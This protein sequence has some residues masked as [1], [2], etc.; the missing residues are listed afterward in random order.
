MANSSDQIHERLERLKAS[1]QQKRP[2]TNTLAERLAVAKGR[3]SKIQNVLPRPKQ[4]TAAE[5][6]DQNQQYTEQITAARNIANPAN[7][8]SPV[9]PNQTVQQRTEQIIQGV[10]AQQAQAEL[11]PRLQL[12]KQREQDERYAAIRANGEAKSYEE[13]KRNFD[14]VRAVDKIVNPMGG[15]ASYNLLSVQQGREE[16]ALTKAREEYIAWLPENDPLVQAGPQAKSAYD[17]QTVA[18]GRVNP[19]NIL[20]WDDH[21]WKLSGYGSSAGNANAMAA[22]K[23][24]GELTEDE[25]R[26]IN[27]L[28]GAYDAETARQ[29]AETFIQKKKNE[30]I[31]AGE[32]PGGNF[33]NAS[34]GG[35]GSGIGYA[36]SM[37]SQTVKNRLL[38]T[39]RAVPEYTAGARAMSEQEA[40]TAAFVNKAE[41]PLGQFARQTGASIGNNLV[42]MLLFG[43][44]APVVMAV[45]AAAGEGYEA[46]QNGATGS[47]QIG[48]AVQAGVTEYL[49][50]KI[51]WGKLENILKSTGSK[52]AKALLAQVGTQ[53][54][55]E[56]GEETVNEALGM[57]YDWI[58]MGEAG[59]LKQVFRK[60]QSENGTGEAAIQVALEILKRLGG[61][62]AGGT[63][64]GGILGGSATMIN[65][66]MDGTRNEPVTAPTE[67]TAPQ[68]KPAEIAGEAANLPQTATAEPMGE[69][70]QVQPEGAQGANTEVEGQKEVTETDAQATENPVLQSAAKRP[71]ESRAQDAAREIHAGREG[72]ERIAQTFVQVE[73]SNLTPEMKKTVF[74]S[75]A[76]ELVAQTPY[77]DRSAWESFKP[78]RD[79]MRKTK[80]HIDKQTLGKIKALG[81]S[82]SEFNKKYG[83]NLTTM[84]TLDSL[85]GDYAEWRM[86]TNGVAKE[87]AANAF[88]A[89]M[90]TLEAMRETRAGII[91][92]ESRN[93]EIERV[94]N[95]LQ[96]Y[97]DEEPETQELQEWYDKRKPQQEKAEPAAIQDAARKST[98]WNNLK[99]NRI[100]DAMLN[101]PEEAVAS[102]GDA[103]NI[104]A[105][106]KEI[107]KAEKR[108]RGLEET[109]QDA[110]IDMA[111]SVAAGRMKLDA[112]NPQSVNIEMVE[113][114]ADEY[115]LII[116]LQESGL[117]GQK[118]KLHNREFARAEKLLNDADDA[119][120]EKDG[121]KGR[122]RR[123]VEAG[124]LMA[125]TSERVMRYIFGDG[126]VAQKAIEE[127]IAPAEENEAAKVMAI[128]RLFDEARKL[129]LNEYES[130]M[131]QLVGE[132]RVPEWSEAGGNPMWKNGQQ[133]LESLPEY[134]RQ[135]KEIRKL[136]SHMGEIDHKKVM[137]AVQ[138][139]RKTY[140]DFF[141]LVNDFRL[142]HG[143]RE[144]G[145]QEDYFPH[146]SN[147]MDGDMLNKTL[148]AF[149]IE[150]MSTLPA[151]VAGMT[152]GFRPNARWVGNFQK[153]TGPQTVFDAQMGF[154][155]YVNAVMDMLYHTD[156]IMRIRHLE[157]AI[158]EQ[159]QT[160]Q[161][162]GKRM[163]LEERAEARKKRIE[164]PEELQKLEEEMENVSA[165]AKDLAAEYGGFVIWLREYGNKLANK[166]SIIRPIES[167]L[168]RSMSNKLNKLLGNYATAQIVGNIRSALANTAIIPKMVAMLGT[169]DEKAAGKANIYIGQALVKMAR[170]EMRDIYAKSEFLSGKKGV[171]PLSQTR[172]EK[173][174]DWLMSFFNV[175]EEAMSNLTFTAKYV[176]VQDAM[177]GSGK[178]AAE[179]EREAIRQ[180]NAFAA[181]IMARRDKA[182]GTLLSS[183]RDPLVR[184]M[185]MFQTEIA[186]EWQMYTQDIPTEIK[187]MTEKIGKKKTAKVYGIALARML[188]YSKILAFVAESVFGINPYNDPLGW[189]WDLITGIWEKPE[190]E[191]EEGRVNWQA[192]S[193]FLGDVAGLVP[194]AS[195]VAALLGYS[196]DRLP[197]VDI[198]ELLDNAGSIFTAEKKSGKIEGAIKT[199]SG[200]AQ[201]VG[202][203]GAGQGEKTAKGILAAATGGKRTQKTGQL[204]DVLIGEEDWA[205]IVRAIVFGPSAMKGMREY[206]D[207]GKAELTLTQTN[208][209]DAA[210]GAGVDKRTA[211]DYVKWAKT[212]QSEKTE[213][214]TTILNSKKRKL[215]QKANSLQ[216]LTDEQRMIL[217]LG[218][219]DKDDRE[220]LQASIKEL[221][222]WNVGTDVILSFMEDYYSIT[223][224]G[225]KERVERALKGYGLTERQKNKLAKAVGWE[226]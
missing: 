88:D 63:I 33:I 17:S 123:K 205:D 197:V 181:Q 158:R 2:I 39:D 44:F 48:K 169:Q 46:A 135:N 49:T 75:V 165:S 164:D 9:T 174:S 79:Y 115:R 132:K 54:L 21:R 212:V 120:F 70:M 56:A 8:F 29:L 153:R 93:A 139:Y 82:V 45:Q 5:M 148:K 83:T 91:D 187:R 211:L 19:E 65:Q 136:V 190:E 117:Q 50:E 74:K 87:D 207:S 184:L 73:E 113:R 107:A 14:I 159:S 103:A 110:E 24:I 16:D 104:R 86:L 147:E 28:Y 95:V 41:T 163:T 168:G 62:A 7:V 177:R 220:K 100:V 37:V 152:V 15:A 178:T 25:K 61:A 199:A 72:Q 126:E 173:V 36:G 78:F 85:D 84:Q 67:S 34:V 53:M 98:G 38:G 215:V 156:D 146:F 192:A 18:K 161:K 172:K 35:I 108:A 160:I 222:V 182:G 68:R 27:Y 167:L 218:A 101:K 201:I 127:Y 51:S 112:V 12:A 157:Q 32:L 143:M 30:K 66:I 193:D 203:P 76:E 13:A 141:T 191:G 151:S 22:Q 42:N 225:K 64:S 145:R 20:R 195:G 196:N 200:V 223:G 150:Q 189:L 10:K 71:V 198:P 90:E 102:I 219:L 128:G 125:K 26:Y 155:M 6:E 105:V 216:G 171:K 122:L 186:N 97:A 116:R 185:N 130:T 129:D 180:A 69:E 43:K 224:K 176:Q 137:D 92:Q 89:L 142:A 170:G 77:T 111:K 60:Y 162:Q 11:M 214:G 210:V 217:F 106:E 131:V 208:A 221:Q 144:I 140:D 134:A 202:L 3:G 58:A 109:A 121:E 154:Q 183:N 59:D 81:M 80:L 166:G 149:G 40:N 23:I 209:Y 94:A 96:K 226:R 119:I 118:R 31:L 179:V 194:Y 99:G 213:G 188:A 47:Q 133:L 4:Q 175:V 138:W 1:E 55:T 52:S 204:Q 206:Y 114:L 57:L 124:R